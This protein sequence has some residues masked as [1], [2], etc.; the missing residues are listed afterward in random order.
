M[1]EDYE[2]GKCKALAVGWEDNT[3]D[4][5][6]R[7]KLCENGLVYTDSLIIESPVAFP[8]NAKLASGCKF[9]REIY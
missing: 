8:I 4:M 2:A 1:I 9:W 3:A 6:I 5:G 7:E